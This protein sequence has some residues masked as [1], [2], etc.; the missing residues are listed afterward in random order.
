MIVQTVNE[1]D[2]VNAF[3][4]LRPNNFTRLALFALFEQLEDESEQM[5]TDMELDVIA[6]CCVWD[7]Y[8]NFE[9]YKAE[10]G[11]YN[12]IESMEELHDYG[13]VVMVDDTR[14]LLNCCA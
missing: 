12:D 1:Y 14:F 8:E 5:E 2:F 3:T 11:D 7:E 10:H 4:E 9:A 6:I 13:V